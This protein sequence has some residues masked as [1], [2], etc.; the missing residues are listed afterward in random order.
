MDSFEL[1]ARNMDEFGMAFLSQLYR[2]RQ[3]E[4]RSP[5]EDYLTEA[6]AEWLRQA[7]LVGELPRIVRDVFKLET[8]AGAPEEDLRAVRWETQHVIGHGHESATNKRPDLVGRGP[9]IFVIIENKTSAPFTTH[10]DDDGVEYSDQLTLYQRYLAKRRE[11]LKGIALLTHITLPPGH[12]KGSVCFWR[13]IANYLSQFHKPQRGS[14]LAF[15]ANNLLAFIRDQNMSGTRVD[16]ADI[17]AQP[18]YDRLQEGMKNLGAIG[19][20]ALSESLRSATVAPDLLK[21]RKPSGDLSPPKFFGGVMTPIGGTINESAMVLWCGV[22]ARSAF[23]LAPIHTGLPELIVGLGI[24]KYEGDIEPEQEVLLRRFENEP[25]EQ[26]G[27]PDWHVTIHK[28]DNY[29]PYVFIN[30]RLSLMDVHQLAQGRDWDDIASDFFHQRTE[31]MLTILTT[32]LAEGASTM[33]Q[34]LYAITGEAL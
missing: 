31:A 19:T 23:G 14:A 22:I 17:V 3:R 12:W 16:L 18:A 2:Y 34:A 24:W 9:N 26:P 33:E 8:V 13:D 21:F 1:P 7:T 27:L 28:R 30:S 4:Q 15:M 29:G 6:L 10:L 25:V 32:P 5:L 20:K 11:G